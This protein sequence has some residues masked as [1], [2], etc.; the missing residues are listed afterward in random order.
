MLL[1]TRVE[2]AVN[3]GGY[4]AT[5]WSETLKENVGNIRSGW[6]TKEKIRAV[7][8]SRVFPRKGKPVNTLCWGREVA[9]D[10]DFC[11]W[12]EFPG[13]HGEDCYEQWLYEARC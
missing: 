5:K 9:E 7:I 13:T 11:S 3:K 6:R 1:G 10:S 2:K 8:G 12:L 4:V